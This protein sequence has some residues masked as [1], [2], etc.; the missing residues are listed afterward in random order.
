MKIRDPRDV[1]RSLFALRDRLGTAPSQQGVLEDQL[2]QGGRV[3]TSMDL[4]KAQHRHLAYAEALLATLTLSVEELEVVQLRYAP[5]ARESG[6]ETYER[7]VRTADTPHEG[8]GEDVLPG[9]PRDY[10]GQPMPGY[11]RVRGRRARMPTHEE[12]GQRVGLT[13]RQVRARIESALSKIR[14][15]L[16]RSREAA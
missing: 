15:H 13:A 6:A 10:S 11:T 3:Q 5:D 1:L 7:V 12:I 2:R 16:S 14:E 8:E 9:T 4:D